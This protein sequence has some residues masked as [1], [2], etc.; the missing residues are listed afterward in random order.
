MKKEYDP[1]TIE[2]MKE[3]KLPETSDA[4]F[5]KMLKETPSELRT[6]H[7]RGFLRIISDAFF[8]RQTL[9]MEYCDEFIRQRKKDFENG[10][11]E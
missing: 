6:E 4:F 5:E 1:L 7:F 9:L 10:K 3:H 8:E 11:N 2:L